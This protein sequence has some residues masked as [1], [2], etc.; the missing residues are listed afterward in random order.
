MDLQMC[1]DWHWGGSTISN[2]ARGIIEE[3]RASGALESKVS[4]LVGWLGLI[5]QTWGETF[6]VLETWDDKLSESS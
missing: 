5:D 3:N 4:V 2:G 6:Q 1:M